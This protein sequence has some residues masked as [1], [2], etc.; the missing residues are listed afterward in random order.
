MSA[1]AVE[2]DGETEAHFMAALELRI[3]IYLNNS[4]H[5]K[6]E[7]LK[8]AMP[9]M[10]TSAPWYYIMTA[11]RMISGEVLK[12]RNGCLIHGRYETNLADSSQFILTPPDAGLQRLRCR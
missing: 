12:Y 1:A 6:L 3:H 5:T 8:L 4:T 11:R 7:K 2:D 9:G 10:R